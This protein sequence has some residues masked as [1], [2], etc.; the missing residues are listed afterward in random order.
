MKLLKDK[1]VL[2]PR[3]DLLLSLNNWVALRSTFKER[4]QMIFL[5]MHLCY[6]VNWIILCDPFKRRI[7][8]R[9]MGFTFWKGTVVSVGIFVCPLHTTPPL[10]HSCS[11]IKPADGLYVVIWKEGTRKRA[12]CERC[13][14]RLCLPRQLAVGLLPPRP[15]GARRAARPRAC[16]RSEL[17]APLLPQQSPVLWELHRLVFTS[18]VMLCAPG[19]ACLCSAQ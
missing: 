4:L 6:Y 11:C 10:T 5:K 9:S 8:L 17:L 2:N 13:P 15:S 1:S 16:G 12:R 3:K 14:A 19:R 18:V 7:D